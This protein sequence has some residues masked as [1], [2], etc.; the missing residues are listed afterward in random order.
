MATLAVRNGTLLTQ[1]PAGTVRADLLV[2]DGRISEI[3]DRVGPADTEV[4]AT[5]CLVLPGFVQTHVHLCQ[6]LF[7]GLAE[8]LDVM[9]WLRRWIWPLETA[10]TA[11]TMAASCR[12]GVAEMLLS[13]TTTFLSMESVLH[14]DEA[15][16]AA[17]DLGT[18]AV[19]GK[20]LMDYQEPGT[21][22]LGETTEE[23]WK[24]LLRLYERWHGAEDGRLRVA[25]SPRA[26]RSATPGLWADAVRLAERAGL[27]LHTHVNENRDQ[28]ALVSADSHGRD[29]HALHSWGALNERMVM[30]HC[31]WLDETEIDLIARTGA[32]VAHCPSANLKLASGV[33]PVPALLSRG[34]N[35]ALGT[36]GAA[37]NN[38]LDLQHEMRLAALVQRPAHGPAVLSAERVLGM[39]TLGG[40]RALGL[41]RELGSLEPGKQA[42]VQIVAAPLLGPD[43]TALAARHLVHTASAADVR[44]VLVGGRI[45]VDDGRLV[46]GDLARIQREAVRARPALTAHFSGKDHT[47]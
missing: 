13:G 30:A 45:V 6:T 33:A 22:M 43:D 46:H 11:E 7:R 39:A 4:D 10:L 29:V 34:I 9:E 18:R 17:A 21:Q 31:V 12:L 5:G 14:T 40:A 28:A 44:T 35:V 2:A 41:G 47:S 27:T 42:D 25:V 32:H 8:D 3:A 19:I 36:D 15:Y 16:A 23:A 37:C 26:P 20:A 38:T 1:G 24:D